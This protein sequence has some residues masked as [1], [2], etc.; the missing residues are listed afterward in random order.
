MLGMEPMRQPNRGPIGVFDSGVGGLTVLKAL[1]AALPNEATVYLGDTA[2]V[3]YGTKS[4]EVVTKYSLANARALLEHDVKLLVVACNTA[5]A[6]AL[7]ALA[8]ALSIPVVGVIAPGAQAAVRA[9]R[10]G[11]VAVIGTPGTVASGAY[12]RALAEARPDLEVRAKACPLFV[13]LAEEGWLEGD[14]PRLV[15]ER[16]LGGDFLA[17]CDT[18]VL[19]C[20]HYPLLA[21]VIAQVAGPS[22]T[23]VD[24]AQATADEVARLLTHHGLRAPAGAAPTRTYLVTDT[25][26]R[27]VE[28]GARFLGQPLSDARQVDLHLG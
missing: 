10:G 24:S 26:G 6:V 16:Y 28:V 9:S 19:G 11:A 25:P 27:F 5:S 21:G 12:Q 2:R 22:V 3:P 8:K 7:P 20:T 15:A 17:G 23:L 4:G 13:P 18:L 14:V 1:A